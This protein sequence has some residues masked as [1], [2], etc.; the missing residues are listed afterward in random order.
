MDQIVFCQ[1]FAYLLLYLLYCVGAHNNIKLQH[2]NA[3][4]VDFLPSLELFP[5][6]DASSKDGESGSLMENLIS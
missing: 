3:G 6:L 2:S 5:V 1:L 4:Q